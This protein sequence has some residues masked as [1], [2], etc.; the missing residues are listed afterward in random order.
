[1]PRLPSIMR[2]KA[3]EPV[4]ARLLSV[5][6]AAAALGVHEHT[7]RSWV[8]KGILEAIHLPG[9]NYS[10][11]RLEEVRRVRQLMEETKG[12]PRVRIDLPHTDPKSLEEAHKLYQEIKEELDQNPPEESLEE[13]MTRLR[14]RPWSS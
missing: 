7:I 5:R 6:A 2:E 12:G 11:F 9:S 13:V 4:G 3:D 10:R 14:G 8:R 1:M